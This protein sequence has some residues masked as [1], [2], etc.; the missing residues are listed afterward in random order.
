MALRDTSAPLPEARLSLRMLLGMVAA[1]L[2]LFAAAY[3]VA[4]VYGQQAEKQAGEDRVIAAVE[5]AGAADGSLLAKSV[6]FD[7]K[8]L[9]LPAGRPLV[10]RLQNEDAGIFHNVAFYRD[11]Q[12]GDL[13]ARGKLFDGPLTRDYRFAAFTP[14]RYFFQCDLH[15]WMNGTLEAE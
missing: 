13:V 4:G 11:P 1:A 14:G 9:R 7:V 5:P 10:V 12:A 6:A 2:A 3:V 8:A 15:P